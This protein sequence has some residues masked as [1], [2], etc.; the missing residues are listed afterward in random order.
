LFVGSEA[1]VAKSAMATDP[2]TLKPPPTAKTSSLLPGSGQFAVAVTTLVT[3]AAIASSSAVSTRTR[4]PFLL[5][6]FLFLF[7]AEALTAP[8]AA[9]P[10]SE[11]AMP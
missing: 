10:A 1:N 11:P 8:S 7:F 5:F 9:M 6:F 2:A 4:V 3:A